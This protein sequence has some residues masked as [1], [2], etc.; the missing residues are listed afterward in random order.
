M[1]K[2]TLLS[3]YVALSSHDAMAAAP[4]PLTSLF[5]YSNTNDG[6]IEMDAQISHAP[7]TQHMGG[8][9]MHLMNLA[10]DP[11]GQAFGQEEY[12]EKNLMDFFN[13]QIFSSIYVGSMKQQFDLIFDTGSSWVWVE[14]E[15]CNACANPQKLKSRESTSFT[16]VS[17]E[18]STLRY[19]RGQVYGYDSRDQIC[20]N[21]ESTI[22]HGCM[23]NY[24]FK[25]VVYQRDL[26]G[27]A[28]AGIIGLSPSAEG[29]GA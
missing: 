21:E 10:S 29:M 26:Q 28:G 17:P 2:A 12:I 9:G 3:A 8:L 24:L 16:Q 7:R 5:Q 1:K 4:S 25:S 19:G 23:D 18:L 13:I 27:L 15:F 11:M 14:H 20:L 22:G 6:L